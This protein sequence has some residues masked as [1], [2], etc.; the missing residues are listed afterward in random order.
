MVVSRNASVDEGRAIMFAHQVTDGK[1]SSDGR[2][3]YVAAYRDSSG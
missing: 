3:S 2:R 1:R